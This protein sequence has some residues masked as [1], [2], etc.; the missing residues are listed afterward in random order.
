[1]KKEQFSSGQIMNERSCSR[2]TRSAV[3]KGNRKWRT[4][5]SNRSRGK[6]KYSSESSDFKGAC[7]R[8]LTLISAL[9]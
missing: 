6:T 9:L 1:M 5:I 2:A 8:G 3:F 7:P 4:E